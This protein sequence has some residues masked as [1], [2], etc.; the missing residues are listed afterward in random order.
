[1]NGLRTVLDEYCSLHFAYSQLPFS[2]RPGSAHILI[3]HQYSLDG[4][5]FLG[6]AIYKNTIR[7]TFC[8]AQ[9]I[10]YNF[11]LVISID[12]SE[13]RIRPV[14]LHLRSPCRPSWLYQNSLTKAYPTLRKKHCVSMHLR[15][16][17][18]L[19]RK[20]AL[21][22]FHLNLIVI[23]IVRPSRRSFHLNTSALIL[24]LLAKINAR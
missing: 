12:Q 9:K 3:R 16:A 24:V 1:M 2:A 5:T 20:H 11:C 8:L 18:N 4:P 17:L 15:H 7:H 22:G 21:S 19:L 13:C 14:P 10:L 23:S 6:F